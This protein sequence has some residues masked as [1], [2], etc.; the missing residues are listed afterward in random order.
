MVQVMACNEDDLSMTDGLEGE[1][2]KILLRIYFL[3]L[4]HCV[5]V[6]EQISVGFLELNEAFSG[7]IAVRFA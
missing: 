5:G 2:V 1:D 6:K 7:R 4:W 3:L